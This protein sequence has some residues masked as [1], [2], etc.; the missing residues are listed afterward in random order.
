MC[1]CSCFYLS[2]AQVTIVAFIILEDVV[3][4]LKTQQKKSKKCS[5]CLTYKVFMM[6]M[7]SWNKICSIT[8]NFWSSEF[9][10]KEIELKIH[11]Y[12]DLDLQACYYYV[13]VKRLIGQFKKKKRSEF[14]AVWYGTIVYTI[15]WLL[16]SRVRVHLVKWKKGNTR[17]SKR[18]FN[19]KNDIWCFFMACNMIILNILLSWCT[20]L[21]KCV[22]Y[23]F[24]FELIQC[25]RETTKVAHL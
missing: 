4:W 17:V 14:T 13:S 16:T 25:S 7:L 18:N 23:G 3:G 2:A 1:C 6:V 10:K 8:T 20:L 22:N 15:V 24:S 12:M 21:E 11:F 19:N 9:Y 5:G